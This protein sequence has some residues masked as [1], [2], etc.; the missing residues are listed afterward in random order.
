MLFYLVAAVPF[1]DD[2]L[3]S[4]E[5]WLREKSGLDYRVKE[6]MILS[7]FPKEIRVSKGTKFSSE[8]REMREL[9]LMYSALY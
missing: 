2:R 9:F 8:W 1:V 6:D 3:E 4:N 7:F 5:E